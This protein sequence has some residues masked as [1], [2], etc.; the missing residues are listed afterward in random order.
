MDRE[1]IEH[2][3]RACTGITGQENVVIIGSQ[4][5]LA[6]FDESQLPEG[7]TKSMEADV[8]F[9]DDPDQ[10][11][12]DLIDGAIGE[13]SIFHDTFGIYA[14]GVDRS[15]A[16]LPTGWESR[17]VRVANENTSN[18]VGL[19]LDPYDLCAA[20]LMAFRQKDL[21]YVRLLLEAGII[22]RA[23]LVSRLEEIPDHDDKKSRARGFL[24]IA[25]P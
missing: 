24:L 15:I 17:L 22:G 4:A 14:Q 23:E 12:A 9:L 20:K 16:I 2:I 13:L 3:I 18:S 11:L 6:S 19:C 5:I 1:E 8:L 21:D 7:V 25:T 10:K